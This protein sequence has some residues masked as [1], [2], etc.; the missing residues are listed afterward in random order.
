MIGEVHQGDALERLAAWTNP[1]G[2]TAAPVIVEGDALEKLALLPADCIDLIATS[3][4]Y[5]RAQRAPEDLGRYRRFTDENGSVTREA[6]NI[7][8]VRQCAKKLEAKGRYRSEEFQEKNRRRKRE[9]YA[10]DHPNGLLSQRDRSR[11]AAL[12]SSA[13]APHVNKKLSREGF[14]HGKPS[15]KGETGL[16]TQI[17]PDDWWDWFRPFALEMLRVLK[18]RRALLLNVGGVVCPTWHHHTYDWDLPSNMKTIGWTFVR[19]IYWHKPNGPPTTAEGTMTNVV[20]HV[21]WFSKGVDGD[22]AP[23]WF[24]WELH[25]TKIGSKTK[26]PMVRNLWEIP[27]G[28]TRWP[29]GQAHYACFPLELAE[30]MVKGWSTSTPY[31][32][33]MFPEGPEI[34]LDPFLGSGTVGIAA[35]RLGRRWIGIEL[36]PEGEIECAR[37]RF[38]ME[39]RDG[40]KVSTH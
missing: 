2:P 23:V 14:R 35:W 34:V 22:H 28:T 31:A 8:F 1:P 15:L 37:A 19:P 5:P 21:L 18:P 40:S 24:P 26:R 9:Q 36:N 12:N 33:T 20:E 39:F 38:A 16:Q 17:H 27:V 13:G 29:E 7:P 6:S 3:P 25:Y 4:P 11:M 32:D 30:R 10:A